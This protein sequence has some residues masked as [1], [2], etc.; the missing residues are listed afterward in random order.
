MKLFVRRTPIVL[1]MLLLG[2][3]PVAGRSAGEPFE[4]DTIETTSPLVTW[5]RKNGL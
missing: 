5:S 4:V 2:G 3:L 1:L